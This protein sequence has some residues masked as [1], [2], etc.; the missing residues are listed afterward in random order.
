[1]ETAAV[2]IGALLTLMIFSFLYKDNVF[3]KFAEHLFVGV[4]AAYWMVVGFHTTIIPNLVAKLWPS[5]VVPIIPSAA[6]A[7]PE[8]HFLI[9]L[10]FGILLLTRLLKKIHYFSRWSMGLVIGYAA[11]TNLIRYL[12]SDFMS[13]ISSTMVP[14]VV[15]H[16]GGGVAIGATFSNLVLFFGV[17]CGLV[18]FFFSREHKGI[19]YPASRLGIWILM[20]TFGASFGYTVMARISLLTGRIQ[21]LL[22]DWLHII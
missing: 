16:P 12:Q 5:L 9:P 18:Y 7:R 21:F 3:Y 11:G 15:Q 22:R 4:S 19:L 8:W 20:I 13:Q 14:L 2:W 10:V 17:F 1:M 6:G